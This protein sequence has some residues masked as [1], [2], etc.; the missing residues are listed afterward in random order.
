MIQFNFNR[1]V[2]LAKWSLTND[3]KYHVKTFLQTLVIISKQFFKLNLNSHIVVICIS[4]KSDEI[5]CCQFLE[6]HKNLLNL[7][8]EDINTTKHHHIV[9]TSLHTIKTNVI[10]PTRTCTAKHTGK[11]TSTI[12]QQRHSLTVKGCKHKLAN[13]TIRNRLKSLWIYNLHNIVVFPEVKSVLFLTLEGNARTA[14]L[15]HSE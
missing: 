4:S 7:N 13:L 3:K 1:F 9:R 15:R 8:W 11:V 2:K 5:V 14:H 12:T 6:L 10:T